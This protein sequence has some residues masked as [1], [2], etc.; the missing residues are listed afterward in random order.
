MNVIELE[1]RVIEYM[2]ESY[3]RNIF[4]Q[5]LDNLKKKYYIKEV[6]S[7]IEYLA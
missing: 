6:D 2:G 7:I 1:R 5:R 4:Y 3:V